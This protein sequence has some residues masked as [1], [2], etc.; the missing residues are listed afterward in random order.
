MNMQDIKT[1]YG[2]LGDGQS[3]FI[4]GRRLLYSL[5]GDEAALQDM[6]DRTVRNRREWRAFREELSE[7]A[8]QNKMVIYGAG[9]WGHILWEETK[10]IVDWNLC[11]DLAPEGKKF[12][13]QLL[14]LS[15]FTDA[16]NGEYVAV[17]SFKHQDSMCARLVEGGVPAEKIIDAGEM[18]NMLTEGSAY[19]DPKEL[20]PL[21]EKEVFV[22]GG[23]YDGF[24][25]KAFFKWSGGKGYAYCFEIL[26]CR[27]EFCSEWLIEL[28]ADNKEK[29]IFSRDILAGEYKLGSRL[30]T[31]GLRE[32]MI[33]YAGDIQDDTSVLFLSVMNRN[34]RNLYK[35]YKSASILREVYLWLERALDINYPGEP[36]SNYSYMADTKNIEEVCNLIEAFGTGITGFKIPLVLCDPAGV[37]V[38]DLQHSH[39]SGKGILG[40]GIRSVH[41]V[42][43]YKVSCR[44]GVIVKTHRGCKLIAVEVHQIADIYLDTVRIS[45]RTLHVTLHVVH[46][47]GVSLLYG[48]FFYDL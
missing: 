10:D 41:V 48:G 29:L 14:K 35:E 9:I 23:C 1:I 38:I 13:I 17:S 15:D 26:L 45:D 42:I 24:T 46:R 12:P 18:I 7:K 19:F 40:A 39:L 25:T 21:K 5:T 3:R 4:Y 44:I 28:T 37:A 43:F 32:K 22:D 33:V 27:G 2:L 31:K 36:I 20:G 30:N 8:A 47:C 11:V 6:V 16:Y 34:K